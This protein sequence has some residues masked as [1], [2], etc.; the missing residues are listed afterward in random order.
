MAI[1]ILDQGKQLEKLYHVRFSELERKKKNLIWQVLCHDFFQKW[2]LPGATVLDIA[3]GYGEFTNNIRAGKKIAVD[4]NPEAKR[5]LNSD[6]E[7]HQTSAL[8]LAGVSAESVDVVFSSNFFEH[9]K[10]KDEM[11]R[12]LKQAHSVLREGGRYLSLQPNLKYVKEAYWDFFDHQLPLTHISA[13]EAFESHGFEIEFLV[14]RFL[15]YTTKSRLPQAP[16]LVRTYLRC[17]WVWP[18]LGKQFF[19][20]AKKVS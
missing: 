20:V 8:E 12:V 13:R 6:V 4:L 19:L 5:A 7:F 3:S 11:G 2:V 10:S 1:K 14:A 15:P 16:W 18:F 17:P 9:L